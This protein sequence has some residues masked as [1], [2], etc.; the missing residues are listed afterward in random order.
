MAKELTPEKMK[1]MRGKHDLI[2]EKDCEYL[3]SF[4]EKDWSRLRDIDQWIVI[5]IL[6]K[7]K[8]CG[9]NQIMPFLYRLME[10]PDGLYRYHA[11]N[12]IAELDGCNQRKFLETMVNEDAEERNRIRAL[13]LLATIFENK[14]DR[15]I[16]KLAFSV[17]E[18]PLS[19]VTARLIAGAAMMFQLGIPWDEDGRPAFWGDYVE[20]LE[21]PNILRAVSETR[22]ILDEDLG[23]G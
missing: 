12:A 11:I 6:I 13:L 9:I 17:Y 18:N 10:S 7:E 22:K 14:R 23:S 16:L 5:E 3:I 15:K 20:E 1:T 8:Q 2:R 19:N 21:H 4:L